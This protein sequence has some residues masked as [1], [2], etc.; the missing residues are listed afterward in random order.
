MGVV[1]VFITWL[2]PNSS[3]VPQLYINCTS[4][5][6]HHSSLI[7]EPKSQEDGGRRQKVASGGVLGSLPNVFRRDIQVATA[8]LGL[9]SS[10]SGLS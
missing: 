5:L 4:V 3:S 8:C 7:R 1:Q 10:V 9:P 2:I 6:Q